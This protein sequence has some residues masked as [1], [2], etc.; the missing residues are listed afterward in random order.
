VEHDDPVSH[1][2]RAQRVFTFVREGNGQYYSK[3]RV[4]RIRRVNSLQTARS[5]VQRIH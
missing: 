1:L 4:Q 5:A 3:E 2:E